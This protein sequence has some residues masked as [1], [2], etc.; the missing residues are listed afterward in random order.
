MKRSRDGSSNDESD[1]SNGGDD[2]DD[3][4][5]LCSMGSQD[6]ERQSEGQGPPAAFQP[7]RIDAVDEPPRERPQLVSASLTKHSASTFS[8]LHENHWAR[9]TSSHGKKR[10]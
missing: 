4:D 2:D 9:A 1:E 7:I 5:D 8:P 3:D 6:G 10:R